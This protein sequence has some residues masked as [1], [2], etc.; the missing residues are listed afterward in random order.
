M[1]RMRNGHRPGTSHISD[2]AARDRT[3]E[4]AGYNGCLGRTSGAFS[5]R[6]DG[7]IDIKLAGSGF[8]GERP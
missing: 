4:T 3:E 2:G 8:L 7:K 1:E 5:H 6:P